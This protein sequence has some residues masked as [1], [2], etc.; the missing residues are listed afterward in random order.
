MNCSIGIIVYN[1]AANIGRLLSALQKQKLQAVKIDEI[2]VVS[3]ACQDGTDEIVEDFARQDPRIR[4][5]TE[6]ERRGKSAAINRFIQAAQSEY[7]IIESG[8]TIPAADTVEKLIAAFQDEK[9]GMSGGRPVPENPETDF[10]GYSVNLLW[11]LHH[12]MAL[13][14]PK[15]GEMVA[16]RNIVKSIPEESAVDEAS[17]EAVIRQQ[18]YQKKYIPSALIHNKGPQTIAEFIMQ[19][20]RIATGHLWLIANQDYRVASQDK[21][22]LLRLAQAEFKRAP[23]QLFWLLGTI[24]LELYSRWLGWIDF[25]FKNK[26]PYKWEIA[27]STK[28]LR[29]K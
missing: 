6:A 21:K 28:K 27:T 10:V 3:S 18:G 23:H 29:D 19:R 16:F 5:I 12:Q 22:M 13:I 9:I 24:F 14:A 8:D 4:L 2:I 15:L 7:L 11:R 25:K 26:N 20:K 1:E 17:I